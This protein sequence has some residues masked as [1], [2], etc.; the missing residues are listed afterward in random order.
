MSEIA[1][2]QL[3]LASEKPG[4]TALDVLASAIGFR[5]ESADFPIAGAV[6]FAQVTRYSEGFEQGVLLSWPGSPLPLSRLRPIARTIAI[7]LETPLL[8]EPPDGSDVWIL[9][10][11]NGSVEN[12]DIRYLD[13]GI[14]PCS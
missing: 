4:R 1:S 11:K 12:T 13:D 9:A 7:T 14:V 3:F 8:L 6:G 5:F 2:L 10:H